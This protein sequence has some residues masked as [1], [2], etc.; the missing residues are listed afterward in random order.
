MIQ[1]D[2][3]FVVQEAQ[4]AVFKRV[5]NNLFIDLDISLEEAL[6][7]FEKIIVHL[8]GHIVKVSSQPKE[9]I[10]PFSSKIIKGEGMPIRST[11]EFGELHVQF[12]VNFPEK[13][14]TNL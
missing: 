6:L 10:Q 14:L 8:D 1:G 11:G 4:H 2:L 9:I 12:I 7:G 3:I 13:D 5:E